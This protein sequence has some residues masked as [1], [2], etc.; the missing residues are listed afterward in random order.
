M[1]GLQKV[2]KLSTSPVFLNPSEATYVRF[3]KLPSMSS[4]I[5]A[6]KPGRGPAPRNAEPEIS[7]QD[8]E[9]VRQPS[10]GDAVTAA[11]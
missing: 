9:Y 11:I 3:L 1:W 10:A 2:T 4:H 6:N 7:V 8:D 5:L